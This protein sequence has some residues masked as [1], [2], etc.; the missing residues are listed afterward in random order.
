MKRKLII[1]LIITVGIALLIHFINFM[2]MGFDQEFLWQ[3]KQ[4]LINYSYAVI[5]G[6]ANIIYFYFLN[7]KNSWEKHPKQMIF[8]GVIGSVVISTLS[9]FLARVFHIVVI[10]GYSFAN[11]LR[12]EHIQNYIFSMLIAFLIT[13]IFHLFYFYKAL[14]E[15]KIREQQVISSE[16]SARLKALKDQ[17]DPHF[18]FNSLNVLTS[19]IEE[20]PEKAQDFT[21]GLS[22]IYRYVL[23][24]K[25]K[26]K[27]ALVEEINF[28]ETYVN[29]LKMRFEDSISV[30]FKTA[31]NTAYYLVP[32]SLQLVLENAVKHNKIS[33]TQ[34]LHLRIYIADEM[35]VVENSYQPKKQLSKRKGV[36][37]KNIE[38]RYQLF[39]NRKVK[40]E[41]KGSTFQVH[42]P[43]L[44]N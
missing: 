21:T 38:S 20:S 3:W 33:A 40:V 7:T 36:G 25:E 28:A 22:K 2:A 41:Q 29:L 27:I 34:I 19:L 44:S 43:L 10:E 35:L 24:Q 30:D 37:L 18:L 8:M 1:Y 26:E 17:L 42:L 16:K 4:I 32:L 14:Q 11:F 13:L 23:D 5:I 6:V 9:F 12:I 39:T 15:S 31:T